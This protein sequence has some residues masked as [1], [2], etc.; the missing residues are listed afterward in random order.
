MAGEQQRHRSP[1][2][3]RAVN[4]ASPWRRPGGRR[5]GDAP[6]AL[7]A[8][9]SAIRDSCHAWWGL[10]ACGHRRL[11]AFKG[12]RK[13]PLG[14]CLGISRPAG[15][16][17]D[18]ARRESRRP[19]RV[20]SSGGRHGLHGTDQGPAFRQ[21]LYE[22]GRAIA[23]A[24]CPGDR[25]G[26]C[27]THPVVLDTNPLAHATLDNHNGLAFCRC[28]LNLAGIEHL[29]CQARRNVS[30]RGGSHL[31]TLSCENRRRPG[32]GKLSGERI[33]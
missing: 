27:D 32:R 10:F 5:Y 22:A 21:R 1:D 14:G 20:A 29:P 33:R 18:C 17:Q 26:V 16:F 11:A 6:S 7:G 19:R 9:P 28:P 30:S 31:L 15:R 4:G 3:R 24:G 25:L 8:T 23:M 12:G 2:A 13:I